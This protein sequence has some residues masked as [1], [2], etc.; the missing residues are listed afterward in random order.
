MIIELRV[1]NCFS[2]EE[3]IVFSMKA[4]MRNKK[5]SSNVHREN[6]F[7]ILKTVGVYGPNNAGK[8]CLVKCISAVKR[9]LLNK[10]SNLMPN[11]FTKNTVCELGVTFLSG[12]RKF[13][14]DLHYD[15]K[16][17]EFLYEK[18]VEVLKD[19]YGNEKEVLWMEK[20]VLNQQYFCIDEKMVIMMPLMSP[21]NIL[22]YV[23]DA[24]KFEH[25]EK[26]KSI[27]IEFGQRIDII[28][29]NNIPMNKTIELMKNKNGLQYKI[30]EFIKNADLYMDNFEYVDMDQIKFD[31]KTENDKPDEEVLNMK[32][33]LMDQIR[34]VSTY[35]GIPVPSLIF[36]STGTK[37]I[38]A[39]ASYIIEGLEKG[40]ILVVDEL[41]SSIH[42][43]LTRAIVA[44]FNNEL[45]TSTQMIFTVHD[46]NL[47]D[48]KKMF[49]K[50][51]IWFIHKDQDGVYVYSLAD[52]TAQKGVRDTTDIIEKYRKG[53]LGALPDPELINSLLD[54][55]GNKKGAVVDEE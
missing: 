42:F 33:K 34:L 9:I 37:K 13:S 18:F 15:V 48:C 12:G 2:F 8:T 41:D 44:M 20:D 28:N 40:R 4:D 6:N 49:R 30:V 5:F 38:A 39:I 55:K 19:Q 21:N 53:V 35:K 22:C 10:K 52:F 54:I 26:M 27:I 45:N 16:K 11:L 14:Y 7:N 47:M 46:V 31:V 43:K 24:S 23:I 50:E 3:Q 25:L 51:Q 1:K 36:D 29:M 32:E 17:E